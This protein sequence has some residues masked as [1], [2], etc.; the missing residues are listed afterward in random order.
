EGAPRHVLPRLGW[1][2]LAVDLD[3]PPQIPHVPTGAAILSREGVRAYAVEGERL[4]RVPDGH[5]GRDARPHLPIL[6]VP[7]AVVEAADP[8]VDG[9]PHDHGRRLEALTQRDPS[10]QVVD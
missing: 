4:D 2:R 8:L 7:A 3:H 5:I 1:E 9:A 6:R 10:E